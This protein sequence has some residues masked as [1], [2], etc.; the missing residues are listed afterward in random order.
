M[1]TRQALH[2][3]G[4]QCGKVRY[5]LYAE[6][7]NAHICHCRM[8]QKAFGSLFAPLASVSYEDF[9]WTRGDPGIFRSSEIVERGFCRDCGTPL[10]FRYTEKDNINI[11]LGSLDDPASVRPERQFGIESRVPWFGDLPGLTGSRTEDDIPGD[12]ISRLASR[13]H[14]DHD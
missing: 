3:G 12:F 2:R 5:A 4:C 10:S 7:G 6:P 9:A 13:Q 11:S 8:C 14:P 1:K